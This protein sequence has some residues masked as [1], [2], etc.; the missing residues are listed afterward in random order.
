VAGV[1]VKLTAAASVELL[2][3]AHAAVMAPALPCAARCRGGAFG[4]GS[5][6]ETRHPGIGCCT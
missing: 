6:R 3:R 5:L 2:G 1:H 4:T